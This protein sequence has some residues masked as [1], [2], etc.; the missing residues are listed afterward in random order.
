ML[1]MSNMSSA[2]TTGRNNDLTEAQ[3][4][5]AIKAHIWKG[6]NAKAKAEQHYIAAGQYLKAL[7]EQHK[8]SWAEWEALLKDKV[9]IGKSRASELMQI[10]DGRK[11]VEGSRAANVAANRRLRDRQ[12]SPSRDGETNAPS[13]SRAVVATED[14]LGDVETVTTSDD[15]EGPPRVESVARLLRWAIDAVLL[16]KQWHGA[17]TENDGELAAA[18]RKAADTWSVIADALADKEDGDFYEGTIKKLVARQKRYARQGKKSADQME[19]L[20]RGQQPAIDALVTRLVAL[21]PDVARGVFQCLALRGPCG[22]MEGVN[23]LLAEPFALALEKVLADTQSPFS[24]AVQTTD[25]EAQSAD[26]DL[27]IPDYLLRRL[28]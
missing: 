15:T 8:G 24:C 23:F 25:V 19:E 9:G 4:I 13:I 16:A 7:K 11:T 10:A 5:K 18:A 2:A 1:A 14:D 28:S 21:D 26:G 22:Y 27:D 17:N 3:H 6:D 12:T 20:R